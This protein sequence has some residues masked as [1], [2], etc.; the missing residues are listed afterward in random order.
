[1][2][3]K[4]AR[5]AAPLLL[6]LVVLAGLATTLQQALNGHVRAATG[7][8]SVATLLNFLVGISALL[9]GARRA[10]A[11]RRGRLRAAAGTGAVVPLPGGPI[12]VAVRDHR[13]VDRPGAGRAAADPDDD[14]GP[15][16]GGRAAGP[17]GPAGRHVE[18]SPYTVLGAL[19]TL[20]AVTVSGRGAR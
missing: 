7:D 5:D 8:A 18:L 16:R 10:R 12:G 2:V 6:L 14:R 15:A 4:G 3:G 13:R 20:V 9:V 19:L 17:A 1:M 11:A